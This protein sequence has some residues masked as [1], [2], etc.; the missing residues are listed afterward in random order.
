[1]QKKD[2]RRNRIQPFRAPRCFSTPEPP[3]A[4]LAKVSSSSDDAAAFVNSFIDR[5]SP[6]KIVMPWENDF[7]APIFGSEIA[8]I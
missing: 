8:S 4:G 6:S 3:T 5:M 1:M 7:M 2:D